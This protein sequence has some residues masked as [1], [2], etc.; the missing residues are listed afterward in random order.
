SGPMVVDHTPPASFVIGRLVPLSQLPL[1]VTSVAF[2]AIRRNVTVRSG[3][4][5]G[6]RSGVGRAAFPAGGGCCA[7]S[8]APAMMPSAAIVPDR[9]VH[10]MFMGASLAPY[11]NGAGHFDVT[12]RLEPRGRP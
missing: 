4:I 7:T 9:R 5:S 8:D 11:S 6:E 3:W 10:R 2:G 1:S 12:G